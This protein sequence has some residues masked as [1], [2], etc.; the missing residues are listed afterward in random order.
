MKKVFLMMFFTVFI[1]AQNLTK[2]A[3][4][5]RNEGITLYRSEMASWHGTDI[6]LENFSQREKI[7][8]YFSYIENDIPR[9][10]FFSKDQK[11]IGTISFPT[12]YK[13]ENSKLDLTERDFTENEKQY[14][15]IREKALFRINNDTIF[16]HYNNASLNIVP[17]IKKNDKKVYV[18]TGPLVNDLVIFGNDYLISF[19][20]NDEVEKV[21]KLHKGI[22]ITSTKDLGVPESGSHSHVLKDQ[23]YITPT[24]ICTLMLYERSIGKIYHVVSKK[25]TSIWN[26][27]GNKLVIITT[28]VM[29]KINNDQKKRHPENLEN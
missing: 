4:E 17:V 2:V 27:E 6:F 26:A 11:V 19:D 10:I 25:Y 3:D 1:Q 9:C 8:G 29:N 12:N 13:P 16:K 22:I 28:E 23:P 7:G 5:I 24:D 14:A 15:K 18:L 20:R 21:E